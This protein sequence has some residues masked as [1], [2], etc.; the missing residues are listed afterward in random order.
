MFHSYTFF[1]H[2]NVWFFIE[3]L[4]EMKQK[5]DILEEENAQMERSTT[6]AEAIIYGQP[7]MEGNVHRSHVVRLLSMVSGLD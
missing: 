7:N 5:D 1:T 3:K 2:G 6:K 4:A